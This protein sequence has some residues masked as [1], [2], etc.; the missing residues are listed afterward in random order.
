M[1]YVRAIFYILLVALISVGGF[2]TYMFFK[3]AEMQFIHLVLIL[4]FL[5]IFYVE[6]LLISI[7]IDGD[8]N[9]ELKCQKH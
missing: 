2:L 6:L 8:C 4:A 9:S 5:C 1:K 3:N 7:M